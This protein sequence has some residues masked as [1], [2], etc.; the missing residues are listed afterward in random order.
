MHFIARKNETGNEQSLKEHLENVSQLSKKFASKFNSESI[1][2]TIGLL[3]DI[4][5]YSL[6][7][8]RRINGSAE[9]V[10]HSTAG[11]Q[12]SLKEYNH[13]NPAGK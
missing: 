11:L 8:Q 12:L 5:K 3:H 13:K 7:F 4:G 1:G 2:C 6:A 10:D 9:Q